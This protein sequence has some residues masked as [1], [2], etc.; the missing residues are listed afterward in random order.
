MKNKKTI[1]IIHDTSCNKEEKKK[2]TQA[3]FVIN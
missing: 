2:P 1:F 3:P